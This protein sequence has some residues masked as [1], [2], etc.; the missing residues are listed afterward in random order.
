MPP[1]VNDLFELFGL[2]IRFLGFL[3]AGYGLGRFVFDHYKLSEWQVRIAL[4][5]GVALVYAMIPRKAPTEEP[6]KTVA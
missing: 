1:V 6:T 3:V 5:A 4:G 2:L